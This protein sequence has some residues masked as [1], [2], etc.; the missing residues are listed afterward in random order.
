[1][2]ADSRTIRVDAQTHDQMREIARRYAS[3]WGRHV[4]LADLVRMGITLLLSDIDRRDRET[5]PCDRS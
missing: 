2:R 5:P 4:S 3:E 1:M